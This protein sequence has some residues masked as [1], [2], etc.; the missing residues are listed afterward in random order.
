M[1]NNKESHVLEREENQLKGILKLILCG[2]DVNYKPSG[3]RE[4][5]PGL[6]FPMQL[7]KNFNTN[8]L[9][10]Y[11]TCVLQKEEV[12]LLDLLRGTYWVFKNDPIHDDTDLIHLSELS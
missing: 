8:R 11:L 3:I 7:H 10:S 2:L 12:S 1:R 5:H 4:T 9:E 6:F